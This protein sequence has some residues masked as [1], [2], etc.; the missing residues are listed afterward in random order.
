MQ[1]WSMVIIFSKN[2][3]SNFDF[4]PGTALSARGG[5]VVTLNQDMKEV[6]SGSTWMD[7]LR[8]GHRS[9]TSTQQRMLHVKMVEGEARAA[10]FAH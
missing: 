7:S 4:A 6:K 10:V 1:V 2:L 3:S 9:N 8:P 5:M